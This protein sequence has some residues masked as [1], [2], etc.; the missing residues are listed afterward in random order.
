MLLVTDYSQMHSHLITG[1]YTMVPKHPE[2]GVIT[3]GD[4]SQLNGNFLKVHYRFVQAVNVVTRGQV[5]LDKIWTNMNDF[6]S[7]P[8]CI[9]EL[10]K[11]DH[12]MVLWKR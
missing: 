9:S 1:I 6:Y 2:C 12:Y 3:T 7:T 8:V 5:T 4:F 10:G 11:S